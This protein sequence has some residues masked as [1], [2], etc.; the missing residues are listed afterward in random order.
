L[1]ASVAI[2]QYLGSLDICLV[3][4][5]LGHTNPEMTAKY[6]KDYRDV[7]DLRENLEK[8]IAMQKKAENPPKRAL[9]SLVV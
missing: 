1:R 2:A 9:F 7:K 5:W 3:Q 4:K 6:I 8:V